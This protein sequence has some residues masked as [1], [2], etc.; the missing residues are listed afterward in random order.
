MVDSWVFDMF[1]QVLVGLSESL[2]FLIDLS[3]F[4]NIK[5]SA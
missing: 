2:T 5:I 4:F 1:S 3:F